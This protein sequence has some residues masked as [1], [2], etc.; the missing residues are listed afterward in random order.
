MIKAGKV[1]KV[2]YCKNCNGAGMVQIAAGVR[3]IRRC[4]VCGGS[5]KIEGRK[6][7]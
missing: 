4:P 6:E 7:K 1:V 3:G 2:E 5:G